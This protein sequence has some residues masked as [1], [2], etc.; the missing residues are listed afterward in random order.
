MSK[1]NKQTALKTEKL[2]KQDKRF[3]GF[4]ADLLKENGN[5]DKALNVLKENIN[6]FPDY[7]SGELVLGEMFYGMKKYDQ[8]EMLFKGAFK[9]D[10]TCVKA[11]KYLAALEE[12]KGNK[13]EQY[14]ILKELLKHDPFDQDAK[15]ILKLEKYDFSET[16]VSQAENITED[17][18]VTEIDVKTDDVKDVKA[19]I[20]PETVT[21]EHQ[22]EKKVS[23]SDIGALQIDDLEKIK[24]S[25]DIEIPELNFGQ[26]ELYGKH[27]FA[28]EIL[29][30]EKSF[31]ED[32]TESLD[33]LTQSFIEDR[34]TFAELKS[35]AVEYADILQTKEKINEEPKDKVKE[36]I[37][38]TAIKA[39][40]MD[41]KYEDPDPKVSKILDDLILSEEAYKE[42]METASK[43]AEEKPN[44]Y[45]SLVDFAKARF[46]F[47]ASTVKKEILYYSKKVKEE[48]KNEKYSHNLKSYREEIIKL[49]KDLIEEMNELKNQYF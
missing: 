14:D 28:D 35:K 41:M 36:E 4:Y 16:S 9:K 37:P 27:K 21:I 23:S 7:V 47:A 31:S 20:I 45:D 42:K 48:P 25:D 38:A 3:F 19:D 10:K 44:D 6:S 2:F 1:L 22:A 17:V 49:N 39:S 11:I 40:D 8:A 26:E 32:M 43:L 29:N 24:S 5:K 18:E 15:N 12:I 46:K 13:K 34:S 30:K 33:S